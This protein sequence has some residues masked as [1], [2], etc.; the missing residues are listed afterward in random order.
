M[1][2]PERRRLPWEKELIELTKFDWLTAVGL[3]H[4]HKHSPLQLRI[5]IGVMQ[6]AD[7]ETKVAWPSQQTLA[8]YAGVGDERQVRRAILAMCDSGA[9][10]RGRISQ[11][12]EESREKVTRHKRGVAYRLNMYWAFEVLEASTKP[13]PAEPMQLKKA[14]IDRTTAVLSDRTTAVRHTQDYGSPPY[15][16]GTLEISEKK[17]GNEE[18]S[19]S[20]RE[21]PASAYSVA[22]RGG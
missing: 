8:Q 11:L 13:L 20:T 7:P 21:T 12:D 4:D 22:S 17:A 19:A 3:S 6:H 9:I 15:K 5:A 2:K 18:G 1:P 16:E 14:H 10:S